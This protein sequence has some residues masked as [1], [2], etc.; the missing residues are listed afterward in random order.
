VGWLLCLED[1]DI[2]QSACACLP[3]ATRLPQ[4][5]L[6][7]LRSVRLAAAD[8]STTVVDAKKL[9]RNQSK[10]LMDK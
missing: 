2:Q 5:S 1:V 6:Q 3:P 7:K 8:G 4:R 10:L 9:A